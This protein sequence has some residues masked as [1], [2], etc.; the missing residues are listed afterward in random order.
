MQAIDVMCGRKGGEGSNE[1]MEGARGELVAKTARVAGRGSRIEGRGSRRDR[2]SGRRVMVRAEAKLSAGRSCQSLR[3]TPAT[4]QRKLVSLTGLPLSAPVTVYRSGQVGGDG[5]SSI[6][7][8][9]TEMAAKVAG[10]YGRGAFGESHGKSLGV[11]HLCPCLCVRGCVGVW[12]WVCSLATGTEVDQVPPAMPP[13]SQNP[14][15]RH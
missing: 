12:V 4:W 8:S 2:G 15:G 13:E 14:I 5:R 1:A 7:S 6:A 10:C 9:P 3:P 11:W